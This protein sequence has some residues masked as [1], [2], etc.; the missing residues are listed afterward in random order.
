[1]LVK[2]A[3]ETIFNYFNKRCRD[4][5]IIICEGEWV[6]TVQIISHRRKRYYEMIRFSDLSETNDISFTDTR[7][8]R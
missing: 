7:L 1:M 6:M 5:N 3:D 8:K 2:I 4:F